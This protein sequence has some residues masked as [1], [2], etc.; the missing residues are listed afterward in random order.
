MAKNALIIE[1]DTILLT[2]RPNAADLLFYGSRGAE[3]R[4]PLP[5][6]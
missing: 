4:L 6:R 2:P 3:P 5:L 1:E